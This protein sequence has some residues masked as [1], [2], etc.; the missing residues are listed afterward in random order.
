MIL[1]AQHALVRLKREEA[2]IVEFLPI[3]SLA[4]VGD[5][6]WVFLGVYGRKTGG[7]E[8]TKPRADFDRRSRFQAEF[9]QSLYPL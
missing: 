6:L 9:A 4:L 3:W 2:V 7:S 1:A 5:T 8:D